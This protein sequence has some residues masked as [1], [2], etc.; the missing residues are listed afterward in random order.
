MAYSPV[1][2]LVTLGLL[3][4]LLLFRFKFKVTLGCSPERK[5]DRALS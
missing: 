5:T 1:N 3:K 4:I 2:L